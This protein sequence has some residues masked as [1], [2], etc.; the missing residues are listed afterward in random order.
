MN[1]VQI[2]TKSKYI[3]DHL[4][5]LGLVEM[6]V[7]VVLVFVFA[8]LAE[9][10]WFREAFAW[11]VPIMLAIHRFAN[12]VWDTVMWFITQ[13]GQTGAIVT[14]VSL[15]IYF[16][17]KHQRANLLS[18]AAASGGAAALNML[19]KLFFSR[20]RPA[21]F[22]VLVNEHSYSFPSGH[23]TASVAVYGF[24]TVL[25]W[26][27]RRRILAVLPGLLIPLVALS[28]IYL[29]VHYPSD[30]LGAFAFSS[31]WLMVVLVIRNRYFDKL[32]TLTD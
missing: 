17:V 22:T 15:A 24:L 21:V 29:G 5:G 14:A 13:M 8:K 28:R 10:V 32:G 9:D 2:R 1:A 12:P 7:A 3:L 11:D 25:L 20:P 16:Y 31:L 23:V 27:N 19:M 30:V 18:I 6:S 4:L 26:Q